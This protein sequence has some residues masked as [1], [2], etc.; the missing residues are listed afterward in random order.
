VAQFLP[1]VS[2]VIPVYNGAA[3]LPSLLDRLRSQTYPGDRVEFL[4]VDNGS[5]DRTLA[6]LQDCADIRCLQETQIQSSYA[7]RNRGIRAAQGEIIAF[8][9]A[10]CRPEPNW[11]RQLVAPL[12]QASVGLVAGEI[13]AWPGR[14]WLEQYA[15]RQATLSQTH[16][17]AHPFC[18]YGQTANLA[19]RA[20]IFAEV[21]L[22]RPYLTTGGDAD[23]CWRILRQTPWQLQF[24]EG[25]IVRHRHRQTL[26]ALVQQW[27]RYGRSNRYLHQLHGVDLMNRSTPGYYAYRLSRWLLKEAPLAA[28]KTPLGQSS[29]VDWVKT[30]LDLL[31]LHARWQGQHQAHLPPL[32]D[33]IA[34]LEDSRD[35]LPV[36]PTTTNQPIS[37]A[38]LTD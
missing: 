37:S 26:P 27:Q 21:G 23:L 31:C 35:Q 2:V 12:A 18:P 22:F 7:A 16:T 25:A 19:V 8:T 11:L 14:T 9:D 15:D 20:Q 32:A 13:Q 28:L 38:R 17:L 24:A 4:L 30:P 1:Q 10:D 33:Q 5:R 3:D 36:V 6:L 29:R 34:W